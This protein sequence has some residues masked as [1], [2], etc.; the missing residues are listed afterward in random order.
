MS[1]TLS[2]TSPTDVV[3]AIPA[4]LGFRPENSLV[5][6]C[7]NPDLPA[8][9]HD[10]HRPGHPGPRDHPP[11]AR[12]EGR[13][14]GHRGPRVV[15]AVHRPGLL[16]FEGTVIPTETTVLEALRVRQ[17]LAAV[18]PS[19]DDVKGQ[20]AL[21][22]EPADETDQ[23]DAAAE[24]MWLLQDV[25]VRDWVLAELATHPVDPAPS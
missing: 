12:P 24:L 9:L 5:V 18:A 20:Y 11:A 16:P 4:L 10:A 1:E 14:A 22:P 19:R 17:G 23:A 7:L 21:R 6:L 3:S 25:D 13:A 2:L 8:R 15:A